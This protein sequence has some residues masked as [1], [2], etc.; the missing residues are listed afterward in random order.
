[1]GTFRYTLRRDAAAGI[2]PRGTVA[3][4][5]VSILLVLLCAACEPVQQPLYDWGSYEDEL[6][7]MWIKPGSADPVASSAR[8]EADIQRIEGSGRAVAPGVRAHLGWLYWQQGLVG[9]ARSAFE[10]EKARYPE[11]T[12]FV[13]GI[14]AR[15]GERGVE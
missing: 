1:M 7:A 14:L 12:V 8:I 10:E 11:A 4:G 6:Y 13:D 2:R 5:A 9:D 3:R 15:L